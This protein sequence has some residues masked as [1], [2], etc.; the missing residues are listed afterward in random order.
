VFGRTPMPT[1]LRA[2]LPTFQLVY[3]TS[4]A[5]VCAL[6]Q[7]QKLLGLRPPELLSCYVIVFSHS[8]FLS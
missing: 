2:S 7:R 1:F 3:R 8:R 6:K 5:A 4:R